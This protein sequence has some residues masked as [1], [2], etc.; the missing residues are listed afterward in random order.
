MD[1]KGSSQNWV[2][3]LLLQSD[4]NFNSRVHSCIQSPS[5][6][7]KKKHTVTVPESTGS[8]IYLEY[9]DLG[10]RF[11][12][13]IRIMFNISLALEKHP[14]LFRVSVL[15]IVPVLGVIGTRA[16]IRVHSS[17]VSLR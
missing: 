14:K 13:I 12:R 10:P 1:D 7:L 4:N 3:A 11:D 17:I 16:W 9:Q 15:N 8:W 2:L 6:N 5:Y